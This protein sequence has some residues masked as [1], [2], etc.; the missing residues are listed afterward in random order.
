M[1]ERRLLWPRRKLFARQVIL[2][3]WPL[4][5]TQT[6]FLWVAD[7]SLLLLT[8]YSSRDGSGA[9][10]Q[11]LAAMLPGKPWTPHSFTPA[12]VTFSSGPKICTRALQIFLFCFCAH[13]SKPLRGQ[14]KPRSIISWLGWTLLPWPQLPRALGDGPPWKVRSKVLQQHLC[15]VGHDSASLCHDG[16]RSLLVGLCST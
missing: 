12:Y 13:I 7:S 2:L 9:V 3:T 11:P 5:E 14:P 6:V 4:Y 1:L 15:T 10:C 8:R 16:P